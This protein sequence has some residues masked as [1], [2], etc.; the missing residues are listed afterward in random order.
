MQKWYRPAE[1]MTKATEG[2]PVSIGGTERKER[3]GSTALDAADDLLLALLRHELEDLDLRESP[4]FQ[5]IFGAFYD[6][7]GQIY[8][9]QLSILEDEDFLKVGTE[10][11]LGFLGALLPATSRDTTVMGVRTAE[12]DSDATDMTTFHRGEDNASE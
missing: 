6:L 12:H 3:A 9:L 1:Y 11:A 4:V 7:G 2:I 8:A 5:I 10:Q